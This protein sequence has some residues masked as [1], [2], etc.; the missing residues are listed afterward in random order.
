[1]G[2]W[3]TTLAANCFTCSQLAAPRLPDESR[4]KTR[5]KGATFAHKTTLAGLVDTTPAAVEVD[6][7]SKEAVVS[8]ELVV[9]VKVVAATVEEVGLFVDDDVVPLVE[10]D[11]AVVLVVDAL[12]VEVDV[13]VVVE[14][15]V[16]V[17]VELDVNVRVDDDV[18]VLDEASTPVVDFVDELVSVVTVDTGRTVAITVVAIVLATGVG[19]GVDLS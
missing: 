7:E 17:L 19:V 2:S 10:E 5:S 18:D 12:F 3:S 9:D 8:V 15:D 11:V 6:V 13:V 14:D 1:M 16:N 4:M